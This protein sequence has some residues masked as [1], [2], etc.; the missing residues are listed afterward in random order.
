MPATAIAYVPGGCTPGA[1]NTPCFTASQFVPSGSE[2]GF[3]NIG[4]NSITGPNYSDIDA[5]L[6][7]NF[8]IKERLRFSV[9]ATASNLLNHPN[10]QNPLANIGNPTGFGSIANTAIAPTSAYGSFQGSAVSGR[11]LVIT[12]RVNF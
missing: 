10:F 2:T 3:G 6:F 4:R 12:G 9:G 8:R 1:V 5:T 11:V 7:K